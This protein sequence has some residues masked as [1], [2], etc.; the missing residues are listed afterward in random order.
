MN[1]IVLSLVMISI[2][3][4]L[5]ISAEAC[6]GLIV[7]KKATIDGSIIIAR[8]EDYEVNNWNKYQVYRPKEIN[9][10]KLWSL[11]NGLVVP[12]PDVLYAYSAMPDWNAKQIAPKSKYFEERGINQFN[13]AVSATTSVDINERAQQSDPLVKH[14]V[15][16]ANIPTLVLP[17]AKTAQQGIELLGSYIE[18]YGAGEGNSLY[19]ADINQAWLMEIGSGHHWIAVKVPDDSYAMLANGLR[20]HGINLDSKEVLHSKGLFE[21]VQLHKLLSNPQRDDFNFAKAF[22]VIG[23]TFN[24]DREW[25]GQQ[26]LSHSVGQQVRQKQYPLFMKPDDK[27]SVN[28]V[29][30]VLSATYENTVLAHSGDRPIRVDR[31]IESHIIQLRPTMPVPFQGVIWQ[32]Y[33]ILAESILIPLY[34]GLHDFPIAYKTGTDT[35]SD[36]SAYW[37][38]RSLTTLATTHPIK[39]LPFINNNWQRAQHNIYQTFANTDQQ[40]IRL[41]HQDPTAAIKVSVDYSTMQLNQMLK[42]AKKMRYQIMTDL[43]KITEPDYSSSDYMNIMSL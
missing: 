26:I 22:G 15:I 31:Q 39:Y 25:L 8:N 33:G 4:M 32:S 12:M 29:A 30:Q 18:K 42:L 34:S 2:I 27:I 24:V 5:S 21:F 9:T 36:D 14:G 6:T 20:I 43:T 38:F 3:S 11:G 40:L 1:I 37:Q 10:T 23:D 28:K 7:G 17:Q 35:Y 19:I 13:V 16:E 41:Y